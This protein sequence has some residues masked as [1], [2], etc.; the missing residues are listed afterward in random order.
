MTKFVSLFFLTSGLFLGCDS[1]TERRSFAPKI[2]V[3]KNESRLSLTSRI[4]CKNS[5]QQLVTYALMAPSPTAIPLKVPLEAHV[6]DYQMLQ[7]NGTSGQFIASV[8][9]ETDPTMAQIVLMDFDLRKK[10]S[11]KHLLGAIPVESPFFFAVSAERDFAL[12]VNEKSYQLYD[13]TNRQAVRDFPLSPKIFVNPRLSP[14]GEY[15]LLSH[16]FGN[17]IYRQILVSLV[18]GKSFPIPINH[19]ESEPIDAQFLGDSAVVWRESILTNRLAVMPL[20]AIELGSGASPDFISGYDFG[21]FIS[22][23]IGNNTYLAIA[24]KSGLRLIHYDLEK[25][26]VVE[27][28]S[29]SYPYEYRDDSRSLQ[30]APWSNH[31]LVGLNHIGKSLSFHT[32]SFSWTFQN[33]FFPRLGPEVIVEIHE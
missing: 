17:K 11:A 13:L 3:E 5:D 8:V 2:P 28:Q 32:P 15:A 14:N 26:T 22:H 29:Y 16:R 30:S 1:I 12:I 27:E 4:L 18:S 6:L 7:S 33:C 9:S 24:G 21:P 20:I 31:L 19:P 23:M 25:L 10:T